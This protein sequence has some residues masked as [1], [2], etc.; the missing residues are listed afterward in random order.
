MHIQKF[1][2]ASASA[3]VLAACSDDS[4][5]PSSQSSKEAARTSAGSPLDSNYR[6]KDGEPVDIDQLLALMPAASRPSYGEAE[7]DASLGATVVT[8][9]R[10]SDADDGEAVIVERAEFYG[11]DLD[12]IERI[13][14]AEADAD[15]FEQVFDKVRFLNVRSEGFED[16][17]AEMTL[18]IDGVEFDSLE[19]KKSGIKDGDNPAHF[20]DAFNLAGFYAKN[21]S[22]TTTSEEVP[23]VKFSAPDLRLVG[24][25]GGKL[26]AM[27]AT[28]LAY[29]I[30][31][32][33]E[34][35]EQ[36]RS[37]MG[38]SADIIFNG[39]L[40]GFIAPD[41]QSVKLKTFEWRDID[42]SGLLEWGLKDER[43]PLS[44]DNLINLGEMSMTDAES[45]VGG[46]RA[47]LIKEAT[48]SSFDFT[49]FV[50]SNFRADFKGAQYDYTAYIPDGED[51]AL[52]VLKEHGLDK[53]T[54]DG[55][56]EWN[57]DSKSGKATLEQVSNAKGLADFTLD[58]SLSGLE[59]DEV[60]DAIENGENNALASLGKFDRFSMTL[61]DE[62]ALD[63][64]FAIAAIEM[65][66]T[67]DDLRQ[68]V[69]AMI[70]LTGLQAAQINP[71]ISDYVNAAAD[72]V[73]KGGSLTIAAQPEE[74]LAFG[75]LQATGTTSPQTLP[76]VLNLTITHEE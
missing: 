26:N 72:F 52:A 68:Q 63:A 67:G 1:L 21:F 13:K 49:W 29:E 4:D 2:L 7:F 10:F 30:N 11:V 25:G 50:P 27:I 42:F 6:L 19:I 55:F 57:W 39:P 66:G 35:I 17:D 62:K 65:G 46:K 3:L 69:P 53:V 40:R 31:Q 18:S 32:T 48:I 9:L 24:V 14:L 44:E 75:A 74:P 12:A 61:D 41:S 64:I 54:G 22:M 43:P 59:L 51:E 37:A 76:D 45:F 58:F 56:T 28:D 16:D 71:R 73:A 15:G 5:A 33:E 47:A 38:P 60:A 20:F 23:S 36:M 34:S 70:R 8:D